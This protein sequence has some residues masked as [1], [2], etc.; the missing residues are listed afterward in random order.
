MQN[1]VITHRPDSQTASPDSHRPDSQT[2]S[3]TATA[4]VSVAAVYNVTRRV[5][6]D[7]ECHRVSRWSCRVVVPLTRHHRPRTGT[8]FV[9]PP[10]CVPGSTLHGGGAGCMRNTSTPLPPAHRPRRRPTTGP[11]PDIANDESGT[12]FVKQISESRIDWGSFYP[13][14]LRAGDLHA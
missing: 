3:P 1:I 11:Q 5:R 6:R 10:P 8:L 9:A 13:A 7:S 2:A 14:R 4:P 12:M